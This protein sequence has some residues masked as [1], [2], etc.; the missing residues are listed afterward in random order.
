MVSVPVIFISSVLA[1]N[2]FLS[3]NTPDCF[4]LRLKSEG[5]RGYSSVAREGGGGST[6]YNGLDGEVPPDRSIF[7]RLQLQSNPVNSEH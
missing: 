2:P 4:R 7:F 6:P 5:M 3:M 1:W